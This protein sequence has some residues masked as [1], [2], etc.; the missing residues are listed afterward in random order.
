MR[1]FS[2]EEL[3]AALEKTPSSVCFHRSNLAELV[4]WLRAERKTLGFRLLGD[5]RSTKWVFFNGTGKN[6]VRV[7][8][9]SDDAPTLEA[10]ARQLR[11]AHYDVSYHG[12][13][14][15]SFVAHCVEAILFKN[16]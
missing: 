11:A 1:P 8:G 14:L 7:K 4:D 2:P 9:V 13:G 3:D 12:E 5:L 16:R 15:P 10:A 6:R